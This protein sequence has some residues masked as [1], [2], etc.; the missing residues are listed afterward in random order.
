MISPGNMHTSNMETEQAILRNIYVCMYLHA[1][2][3]NEK[4]AINLNKSEEGY[5]GEFGRRKE[6]NVVMLY[7][8]NKI[9]TIFLSLFSLQT[10]KP[11]HVSHIAPS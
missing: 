10:S 6:S 5:I 11:A 1:I 8:Q 9:Y 4:E 2:M 7:S 3:I